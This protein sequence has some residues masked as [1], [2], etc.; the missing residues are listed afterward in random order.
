MA[1]SNEILQANYLEHYKFAK[2]L[3]QIYPVGH[4]RRVRI[5]KAMNEMIEK[6]HK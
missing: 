2:D 3:A 1:T 6:L 4:P 5:E